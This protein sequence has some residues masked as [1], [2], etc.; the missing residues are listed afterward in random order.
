LT[1]ENLGL[2]CDSE[3][4]GTLVEFVAD[5]FRRARLAL[6]GKVRRLPCTKDMENGYRERLWAR[7]L[8]RLV[9]GEKQ[10]VHVGGWEHLV[11]WPDGGGLP[12]LLADLKPGIMLLDEAE[13]IYAEGE[14]QGSPYKTHF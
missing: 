11:P 3:A 1:P 13:Q 9:T 10:V 2:L 8:R 12:H 7:R 5:S 6:K 4:S 14:G